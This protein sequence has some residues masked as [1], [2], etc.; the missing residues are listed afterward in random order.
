MQDFDKLNTIM[1]ECENHH[2]DDQTFEERL[3]AKLNEPG[4]ENLKLLF[5]QKNI[6]KEDSI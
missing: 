2:H 1:I 6:S 5:V 3:A 4:N